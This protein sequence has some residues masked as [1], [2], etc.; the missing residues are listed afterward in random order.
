MA[1]RCMIGRITD[2]RNL[3]IITGKPR[4]GNTRFPHLPDDCGGIIGQN[5][6]PFGL[7]HMG[8]R[9]DEDAFAAVRQFSCQ[10]GNTGRFAAGTGNGQYDRDISP[11]QFR[12]DTAY[13]LPQGGYMFIR[14]FF[15]YDNVHS[16]TLSRLWHPLFHGLH[17]GPGQQ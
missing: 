9:H 17:G 8:R 16:Y 14:I 3:A 10:S 15:I 4:H 5:A 7:I 13:A 11:C 1:R 6:I 12:Q 2:I